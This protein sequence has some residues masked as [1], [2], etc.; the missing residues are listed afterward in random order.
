M[1]STLRTC[2]ELGNSEVS[3][4]FLLRAGVC[5]KGVLGY[6]DFLAL[7]M[8]RGV[9]ESLPLNILPLVSAAERKPLWLGR[10]TL[11]ESLRPPRGICSADQGS[12]GWGEPIP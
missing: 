5:F 2:R 3:S 12:Q 4:V 1:T 8:Q 6:S 11:S 7:E 9:T 10:W